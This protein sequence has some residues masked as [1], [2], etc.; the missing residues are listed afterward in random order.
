[1]YQIGF[2]NINYINNE[3][4]IEMIDAVD[5]TGTQEYLNKDGMLCEK[6]Y[7][8]MKRYAQGHDEFITC[9]VIDRLPASA[10]RMTFDREAQHCSM[11]DEVWLE[12]DCS[13]TVN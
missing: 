12:L 5:L 9:M 7:R 4:G 13:Y 3:A 6:S 8:L 10:A 11:R 2:S 1:M